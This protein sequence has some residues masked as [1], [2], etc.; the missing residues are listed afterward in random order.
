MIQ[1][2]SIASALLCASVAS[3]FAAVAQEQICRREADTTG[4]KIVGGHDA[5]ADDWPG[6]ASL[7][8]EYLAG[9]TSH[10]CGGTM[11][12][13][14]WMLT[15]AHCVETASQKQGHWVYHKKEGGALVPKGRRII[16][17]AGKSRLDDVSPA[18]QMTISDIQI[19][20]DYQPGASALG[21]DIALV[22]LATPYRGSVARLSLI[23]ETDAFTDLGE[24]AEVAGYGLL[25]ED[26]KRFRFGYGRIPGG[27]SISAP[28]LTLQDT[29]L[30]TVST[31]DCVSRL[32]AAI[33]REPAHHRFA[34]AVTAAQVCAGQPSGGADSC[35]GDSGGPLVKLNRN[36]C[37]YQIGIVSWGIGCAR[38]DTPGVYTRVSAYRAWIESV[39]GPLAD[40]PADLLPSTQSGVVALF[41]ALRSELS[42]DVQA[43]EITL[44]DTAGA[45][46]DQLRIG[47]PVRIRV[48]M[49]MAG[50]LILF[51]YD[52]NG[53][54]TQIYPTKTE[55]GRANG[56]PVFPKGRAIT[57]P[58]DL[59]RGQFIAQLPT[60][61]QA[62]L[63]LIVPE[64]TPIPV[65]SD[66]NA[67]SI[68][69]PVEYILNVLRSVLI[70]T[71]GSRGIGR[72]ETGPSPAPSGGRYGLPDTDRFAIGFLEYDVVAK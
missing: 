17:V 53:L 23:P 46:T 2:L 27:T 38:P 14:D 71:D 24:V 22:R 45:G 40:E 56:W 68:S 57:G 11:I 33:A 58:G 49:P 52:A 62:L 43:P 65:D 25:D 30:A 6:I 10:F 37:P 31:A 67:M 4:S 60:G 32:R 64:E 26:P 21:N 70:A 7:Q 42:S 39:T 66:V 20:P 15:A 48:T 50:K 54:L 36:G 5:K 44:L 3:P 28:S 61:R 59:F 29:A 63:A 13:P 55:M 47:Q 69:N 34:Y 18:D 9:D 51:D 16:A 35:Q 8:I 41:S 12:T 1:R 19:H 72:F